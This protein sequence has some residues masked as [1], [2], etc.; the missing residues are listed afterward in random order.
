M[1]LHWYVVLFREL[2]C[3]WQ[4]ITCP[5]SAVYKLLAYWWHGDSSPATCMVYYQ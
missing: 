1:R 3:T 2:V 5:C 4:D